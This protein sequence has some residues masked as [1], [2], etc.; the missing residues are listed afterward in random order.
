MRKER[1]PTYIMLTEEAKKE[2]AEKGEFTKHDTIVGAGFGPFEDKIGDLI[3]WPV[4]RENVEEETGSRM[5]PIADAGVTENGTPWD[6][7]VHPEKYLPGGRRKTSGYA[8]AS[9][10]PKV[11]EAYLHR[12]LVVVSGM[13]K[14]LDALAISFQQ[15]GLPITYKPAEV[16]L[17]GLVAAE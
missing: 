14:G 4:V 9:T 3:Q 16:P 5:V 13:C 12:R 2:V 8:L 11:A 10:K 17:L 6:P 1:D 7:N 15:Q